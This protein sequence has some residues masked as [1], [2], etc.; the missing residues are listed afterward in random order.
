MSLKG[1]VTIMN[2]SKYYLALSI[3]ITL[4]SST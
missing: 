2:N 3:Y 1:G 4:L